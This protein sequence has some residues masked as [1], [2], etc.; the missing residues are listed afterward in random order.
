MIY[1]VRTEYGNSLSKY[2]GDLWEIPLNLPPQGLIQSNG[3][4]PD[5]STLVSKPLLNCLRK[6]GFGDELQCCMYGNTLSLVGY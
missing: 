4:S 6:S 3:D 5:I 1:S 2:V